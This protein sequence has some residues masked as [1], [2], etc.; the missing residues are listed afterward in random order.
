MGLLRRFLYF[1]SY[2][3]LRCGRLDSSWITDACRSCESASRL[4]FRNAFDCDNFFWDFYGLRLSISAQSMVSKPSEC[5]RMGIIEQYSGTL[6]GH[7]VGVWVGCTLT[8]DSEPTTKCNL[9][10]GCSRHPRCPAATR[11]RLNLDVRTE[12]WRLAS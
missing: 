10:T 6:N 7:R 5:V 3:S 8:P 12:G 11:L 4:G 2:G 9:T 1:C